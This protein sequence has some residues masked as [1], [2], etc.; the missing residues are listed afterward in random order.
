MRNHRSRI[1][2]A[3]MAFAVSVA[4]IAMG[5]G[6][7]AAAERPAP[8]TIVASQPAVGSTS[9]SCKPTCVDEKVLRSGS[10]RSTI[11]AWPVAPPPGFPPNTPCYRDEVVEQVYETGQGALMY[12][13]LFGASVCLFSNQIVVYGA[14]SSVTY[15]GGQQDPRLTSVTYAV[16]D[17]IVRYSATEEDAYSDLSVTF[18]PVLV[19]GACQR[20]RHLLG[21]SF[22][23]YYVYPF[24][25]FRRLA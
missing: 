23:P 25:D 19:P 13:F 20:Y 7:A 12:T 9:D 21:L 15:P 1:G 11:N 2:L 4:S 17:R 6:S 22:N 8:S 24:S 10:P 18:C 16:R 5:A 14:E 3:T